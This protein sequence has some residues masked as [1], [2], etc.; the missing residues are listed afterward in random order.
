MIPPAAAGAATIAQKADGC[1]GLPEFHNLFLAGPLTAGGDPAN[2]FAPLVEWFHVACTI[3]GGGGHTPVQVAALQPGTPQ[4]ATQLNNWSTGIR[5]V[6]MA[7]LGVGGPGLTTAA[8]MAGI[9]DLTNILTNNNQATIDH[10]RNAAVKTFANKHSASLAQHIMNL[11]SVADK[12]HLPEVHTSPV[13]TPKSRECTL[14]GA[15]FIKRAKAMSLPISSANAPLATTHLV[16][17]VF[18]S[19]TP[20]GMGLTF[21][22]GLSPFSIICEGHKEAAQ[23]KTLTSNTS[24]IELGG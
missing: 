12:A 22:K 7:R 9:M 5:Q 19:Y 8:F 21:A 6:Q 24:K 16:D 14:I 20:G 11:C 23:A 1:C 10:H 18:H 17:D 2:K 4:A 13:N 15:L 3:A